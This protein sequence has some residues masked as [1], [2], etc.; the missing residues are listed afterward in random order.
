MTGVNITRARPGDVERIVE[1]YEWL[2]EPP[3]STPRRWDVECA[4]SALRR[5]ISSEAAA[6]LIAMV[7]GQLVGLCT[8]YEN[9]ESVRFGRRVRVEE[10][11][12]HPEHR[13]RRIGKRLL[14]E[15]KRWAQ[16]R[17]AARLQLDSSELRVDAHR[18]YE[19][20]RPDW[21]SLAYGWELETRHE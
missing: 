20:E 2:F 14:N 13:S 21:R 17:G 4:R 19:R 15:A 8:A 7:D 11:A 9:P 6:V 5:A 3:G 12:V 16:S 10:L 18:F 1:A